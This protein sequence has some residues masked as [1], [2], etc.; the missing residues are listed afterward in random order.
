MQKTYL[1]AAIA[2]M[3]TAFDITLEGPG[4]DEG[5][6]DFHIVYP[7]GETDSV[8][9]DP[10]LYPAVF[11]WPKASPRCGATMVTPRVALTAAHCVSAGENTNPDLTMQIELTDGNNNYTTYNI[12][13]IRAN[14]CWFNPQNPPGMNRYSADV[15]ILILDRDITPG[16]GTPEEGVHYLKPWETTVDGSIVGETFILA[17]WGQSGEVN[18]EYDDS[19]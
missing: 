6:P 14:E 9:I 15:A 4:K 13:D 10:N 1:A 17:G 5:L 3:T 2:A 12:V 7:D 8:R 18:I 19:D 11:K 16:G